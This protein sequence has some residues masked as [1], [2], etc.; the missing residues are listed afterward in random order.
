M[1]AVC[2]RVSQKKYFF[3]M[4]TADPL[5]VCEIMLNIHCKK[6]R[7]FGGRL[8]V[9]RWLQTFSLRGLMTSMTMLL[10]ARFMN[11]WE[12]NKHC[13]D[14]LIVKYNLLLI[15][16]VIQIVINKANTVIRTAL[17]LKACNNN[18]R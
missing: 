5:N 13:Y 6:I 17:Y 2:T 7:S 12:L 15:L 9:A 10:F 4:L 14:M 1:C 8:E 16:Y 11:Y 3:E 18:N